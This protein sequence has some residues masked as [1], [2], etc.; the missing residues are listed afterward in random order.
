M[1]LFLNYGDAA[2]MPAV[3]N[4]VSGGFLYFGKTYYLKV[5]QNGFFPN[6]QL[7]INHLDLTR[8]SQFSEG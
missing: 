5:G 8:L 3:L 1:L 6:S 4:E 7:S 2:A